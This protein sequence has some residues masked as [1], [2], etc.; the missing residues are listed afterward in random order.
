MH[1]HIAAFVVFTIA[2]SALG[3]MTSV[4]PA[5]VFPTEV[6]S[7]G[8][9]LATGISRLASAAGTFLLPILLADAGLNATM[10]ALSALCAVAAVM[11]VILGPETKDLL[12]AEASAGETS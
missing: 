12:L 9:G 5:E 2:I 4:Y 11:C 1:F 8:I 6:R 7:T 3:D 10:G